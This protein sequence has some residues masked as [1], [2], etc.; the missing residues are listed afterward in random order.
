MS[1]KKH[2]L[3]NGHK[4]KVKFMNEPY[5]SRFIFLSKLNKQ[6]NGTK[7]LLAKQLNY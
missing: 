3:K 7:N 2:G 4:L 6:I 1:I 5:I